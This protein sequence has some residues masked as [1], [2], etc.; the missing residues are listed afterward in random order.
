MPERHASVLPEARRVGNWIYN[1]SG[2]WRGELSSTCCGPQGVAQ[3][4]NLLYRRVALGQALG[5]NRASYFSNALQNT[6]LRYSRLEIC[7][8]IKKHLRATLHGTS[9][10]L[11]VTKF[12]R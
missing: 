5:L 8:T 1:L 7:A 10:G 6:I 12:L 4:F 3:I 2:H 9:L 11:Q